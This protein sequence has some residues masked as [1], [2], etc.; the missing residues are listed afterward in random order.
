MDTFKAMSECKN[1][2]WGRKTPSLDTYR[3]RQ[4]NSENPEELTALTGF[5]KL[6]YLKTTY[7]CP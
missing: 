6:V 3:L 4:T 1:G 7:T 5:Q 2:T